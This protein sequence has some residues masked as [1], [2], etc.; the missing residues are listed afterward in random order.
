[1]FPETNL[2]SLPEEGMSMVDGIPIHNRFIRE[3]LSIDLLK[4][5]PEIRI[6][7]LVIHGR[8]DTVVNTSN[9]LVANKLLGSKKNLIIIEDGDHNLTR[10]SDL[11]IMCQSIIRWI[12]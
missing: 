2:G 11:T 8:E 10:D 6:P 1:M 5:L 7:V 9:A 3:A 12:S 4:R